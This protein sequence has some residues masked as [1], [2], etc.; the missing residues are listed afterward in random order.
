MSISATNIGKTIIKGFAQGGAVTF[1]TPYLGLF[2][3]LPGADGTGGT[4]VSYPEYKRVKI[5]VNGIEGKPIMSEPYTE[6]GSGD[7]AGKVLSATKNQ[8]IIYFPENEAGT[9]E[10][11]VVG[12][13]LFVSQSAETPY[14]WGALKSEVTIRQYTVPM[15]RVGDFKLMIK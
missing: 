5:N 10:V 6:Q 7:D 11:N 13:G 1:P 4:E 3:Q 9:E 14:L 12:F 15:F 8:E 2:T